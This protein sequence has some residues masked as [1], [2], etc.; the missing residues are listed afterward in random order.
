M[1][2]RRTRLERRERLSAAA[3]RA[4]R[5]WPGVAARRPAGSG[6]ARLASSSVTGPGQQRV[7]RRALG[8]GAARAS[9]RARARRAKN[10]TAAGA[11]RRAALE[12]VQ[13][14]RGLRRR[15]GRSRARR[16]CRSG[17]PRRRPPAEA[18]LQAQR[19]SCPASA[20]GSGIMRRRSPTTHP[21]DPREVALAAHRGEARAH[22]A[23]RHRAAPGPRRPRAPAKRTR[24]ARASCAE[25]RGGSRASPSAPA[26]SAPGGSWRT[27]SARA[28][29]R[30]PR[31]RRAGWRGPR[32]ARRASP[33]SRSACSQPTSRPRRARVGSPPAPARRALTSLPVTLR[34]GRSSLQRQRDRAAAG[35]DVEHARPAGSASAHSTS[36]SVSGRGTRRAAVDG[37]LE[38]RKP[39][40]PTM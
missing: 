10:M 7:E 18:L 40:R 26:N 8:V 14:P 31:R 5:A 35:A 16:R 37:Q 33:S 20:D 30:S 34:S 39:R 12:L 22:A 25:Q 27:I 28:L 24:G 17:T 19:A 29:P 36:S 1:I 15:R 4:G 2:G 21:L 38:R 32:R 9:A 11:C 23:S 13:P 3:A 6:A